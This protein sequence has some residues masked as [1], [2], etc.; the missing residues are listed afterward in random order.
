MIRF[1]GSMIG[2]K[3]KQA[4]D[5][6]VSALV[7]ADPEAATL[8]QLSLMEADLDRAGTAISGLMADLDK[9]RREAAAAKAR[10]AHRLAAAVKLKARADADDEGDK[11]GLA[12]SL[13]ALLGEL[14]DQQLDADSLAR[15]VVEAEA[16][17]AEA[18][19][20]YDRKASAL[21]KANAELGR[22]RR[23]LARAKLDESRAKAQAEKA[24]ENAGLRAGRGSGI[25]IAADS[26]ARN[27]EKSR[28]RAAAARMKA[29][30][31]GAASSP[32]ANIAD[33]LKQAKGGG[34]AVTAAERL[35]AL[36]AKA[37]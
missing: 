7:A 3:S 10:Q 14:E 17:L 24:V 32:D 11:A 12:A 21:G 1:L 5:S 6:I 29:E 4:G 36:R 31:L 16:L 9:S 25:T 13:D 22:S 15:D 19:A 33:A 28:A 2:I 37:A 8:A 27:T 30:A 34:L 35:A 20:E 23:E 26:M 18:K